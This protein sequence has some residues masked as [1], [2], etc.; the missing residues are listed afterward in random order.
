VCAE[1]QLSTNAG[2]SV[3]GEVGR[4]SYGQHWLF[5]VLLLDG[6]VYNKN[7]A[8]MFGTWLCVNIC[9]GKAVENV[10]STGMGQRLKHF[11]TFL[12]PRDARSASAVLLS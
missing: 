12:S 1:R 2:H 4:S 3:V 7:V 11:V 6:C 8:E 10:L 5:I 9:V